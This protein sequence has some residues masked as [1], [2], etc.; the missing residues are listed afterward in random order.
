MSPVVSVLTPNIKNADDYKYILGRLSEI[1][2]DRIER[3]S[4]SSADE[5]EANVMATPVYRAF[6][7]KAFQQG[8]GLFMTLEEIE[9]EFP[10]WE[11]IGDTV[12]SMLNRGI[13]KEV[14]MEWPPKQMPLCPFCGKSSA[15][16]IKRKK[17]LFFTRISAWSCRNELCS[18]CGE[19]YLL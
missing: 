1:G 9:R 5:W 18:M 16:P 17:L 6:S 10:R 2:I 12:K 13:L 11:N 4:A 19:H 7:E 14:H 3:D 15:Y 8:R